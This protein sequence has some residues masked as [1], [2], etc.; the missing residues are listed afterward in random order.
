MKADLQTST[1]HR[2]LQAA[3]CATRCRHAATQTDDPA[4]LDAF[5]RMAQRYSSL[6]AE[7]AAL[8]AAEDLR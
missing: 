3:T 2:L 1:T 8:L 5:D 4:L 7:L 6:V